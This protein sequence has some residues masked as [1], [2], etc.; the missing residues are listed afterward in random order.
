MFQP[1]ICCLQRIQEG[2]HLLARAQDGFLVL[3][4]PDTPNQV[5]ARLP[6][7]GVR[8]EEAGLEHD[9]TLEAFRDGKRLGQEEIAEAGCAWLIADDSVTLRLVLN[10]REGNPLVDAN[11]RAGGMWIAARPSMSSSE[12]ELRWKAARSLPCN[13][14][15]TYRQSTGGRWR[16]E[17]EGGCL[18]QSQRKSEPASGESYPTRDRYSQWADRI[19]TRPL[20]RPCAVPAPGTP[21]VQRE[22][23]DGY[24]MNP[25]N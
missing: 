8:E 1:S 15:R 3:A 14:L 10:H 19:P 5:W 4:L 25:V 23:W 20:A 12:G 13:E 22:G 24:R 2:L 6:V 11:W 17:T 7:E 9:S 16:I 18:N 21:L